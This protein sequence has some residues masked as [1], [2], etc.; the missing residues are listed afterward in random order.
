MHYLCSMKTE[1]KE[2]YLC[3]VC[4]K[5]HCR[6]CDKKESRENGVKEVGK[7]LLDISKYMLTAIFLSS[8]FTDFGGIWL[9]AATIVAIVFTFATGWLLV[10]K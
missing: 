6:A 8:I 2:M 9:Y 4:S 3:E 10:R 5:T 7:W 1:E